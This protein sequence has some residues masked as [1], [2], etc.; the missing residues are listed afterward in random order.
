MINQIKVIK[1]TALNAI[2]HALGGKM[3]AFA[4]YEMPVQ[5]AGVNH[6]HETVRN[7]VGIFDV[8]HMGEILING[9]DALALI[10]KI[11]SNDA[12]LLFP[13]KVQ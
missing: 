13:G 11:S 4:G 8:S 10:Q 2:H 9:K 7:A 6:E 1:K 3:T 5:Y 12:S